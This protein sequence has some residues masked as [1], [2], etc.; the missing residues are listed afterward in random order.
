MGRFTWY[1]CPGG[2]WKGCGV[3][4]GTAK[5]NWIQRSDYMLQ[6]SD[7]KDN[8]RLQELANGNKLWA[9]KAFGRVVFAVACIGAAAALVAGTVTGGAVGLVILLGTVGLAAIGGGLIIGA[10][11]LIKKGIKRA[12]QGDKD[13]SNERCQKKFDD[14]PI[15]LPDPSQE[16]RG[17]AQ[18]PAAQ[19]RL[20]A[21]GPSFLKHRRHLQS[22]GVPTLSF[23]DSPGPSFLK[24][25]RRLKSLGVPTAEFWMD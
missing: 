15:L 14:E 9:S 25:R 19:R 11:L 3:C 5:V 22:L 17:G 10:G 24:R 13:A 4:D 21:P 18:L 8:P 7:F 2:G 16:P 6:V 23:D 12:F 1:G 20:L